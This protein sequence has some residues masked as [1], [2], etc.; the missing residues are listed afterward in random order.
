MHAHVYTHVHAHVYIQAYCAA[1][2]ALAKRMLPIY[3]VGLDMPSDHF[4]PV[5]W[6]YGFTVLNSHCTDSVQPLCSHCIATTQ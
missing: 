5:P 6:Q 3:A 4:T 2:E 1:M